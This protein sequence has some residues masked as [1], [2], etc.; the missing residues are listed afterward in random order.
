[1]RSVPKD[2]CPL[3]PR[4][5]MPP[6]PPSKTA[7]CYA[8]C[9]C[10]DGWNVWPAWTD[11]TSGLP[12]RMERLACPDVWRAERGGRNILH[13]SGE[14]NILHR[15][16]ERNT[17]HRRCE[18]SSAH[19][20]IGTHKDIGRTRTSGARG[21]GALKNTGRTR[22]SSSAPSSKTSSHPD[23]GGDALRPS[24]WPV[25]RAGLTN[26]L[27][28]RTRW[29]VERAGLTNALDCRTRWTVERTEVLCWSMLCWSNDRCA[30]ALPCGTHISYSEGRARA[31]SQN[32]PSKGEDLHAEGKDVPSK[33]FRYG[34]R[35]I[36]SGRFVVVNGGLV[37]VT[38]ISSSRMSPRRRSWPSWMTAA[39]ASRMVGWIVVLHV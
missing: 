9:V 19:K 7:T 8:H 33:G 17:P 2:S 27:D 15:S 16:G 37:V 22:I 14:R 34:S 28:C 39:E 4:G 10:A 35:S 1:M 11:G 3:V 30:H 18:R 25:E 6:L 29:T 26:A 36:A 24:G 31:D 5:V 32:V 38:E 23:G 12:G 21:H 20:N 13:R